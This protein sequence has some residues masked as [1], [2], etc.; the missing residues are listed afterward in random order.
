MDFLILGINEVY[1]TGAIQN[2]K[3]TPYL[4]VNSKSQGNICFLKVKN[5]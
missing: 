5:N 4:G 1:L 2:N 3:L